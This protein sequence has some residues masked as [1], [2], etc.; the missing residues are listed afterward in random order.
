MLLT[1]FHFSTILTQFV[2]TSPLLDIAHLMTNISHLKH[3]RHLPWQSILSDVS[4]LLLHTEVLIRSV[5]LPY[6][7]FSRFGQSY[8][9]AVRT[10]SSLKKISRELEEIHPLGKKIV[11]GKMLAPPKKML[12]LKDFPINGLCDT[13]HSI[14]QYY[15]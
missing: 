14:F 1:S 15:I 5:S 12:N 8:T 7:I 9:G 4:N 11:F 6:L 13:S 2:G 3:I 10:H